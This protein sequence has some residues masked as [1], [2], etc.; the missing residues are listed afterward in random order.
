MP[1]VT[2]VFINQKVID[3]VIIGENVQTCGTVF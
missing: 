3:E 1:K 2:A